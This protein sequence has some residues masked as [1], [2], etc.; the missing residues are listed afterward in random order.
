MADA[1][2]VWARRFIG[3]ALIQ[4]LIMFGL[5]MVLLIVDIVAFVSPNSGLTSP[6]SVIATGSAGTWFT[7]GYL[8]YLIVP[9]VGTGLS[10]LF[11]HYIEVVMG[12]PYRG[13]LNT[14]AWAHLI[15]GNVAIGLA[16]GLL[17]YGGYFGGAAMVPVDLGG[18]GQ[19]A[20]WVHAHILGGLTAPISTLFLVGA[21]GPL[22]GGIGYIRAFRRASSETPMP[23]V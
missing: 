7:I 13:G 14:L 18:G 17:M 21:L 23:K 19:S 15:L 5:T 8:G 22:F 3:T 10:A 6:E 9:V 2:S 12:H 20:E 1:G 11:Y 16:L 4:G